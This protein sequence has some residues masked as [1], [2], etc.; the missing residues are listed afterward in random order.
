MNFGSKT[1]KIAG[2]FFN[3]EVDDDVGDQFLFATDNVIFRRVLEQRG[4]TF[5]ERLEGEAK[6]GIPEEDLAKF[7][8]TD[9][10]WL[11]GG[12]E[13][14]GILRDLIGEAIDEY[15]TQLYNAKA[16]FL[17][18][19]KVEKRIE[20]E[21]KLW[22]WAGGSRTECNNPPHVHRNSMLSGIYYIRGL[23]RGR[24]DDKDLSG[25]VVFILSAGGEEVVMGSYAAPHHLPVHPVEGTLLIFPSFLR[26]FVNRY[27]YTI[28]ERVYISFNCCVKTPNEVLVDPSRRR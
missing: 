26:H 4:D 1:K 9:G 16:D 10:N 14:R 28:F 5:H 18:R 12:G 15:L 6:K 22:G 24:Y 21:I 13:A 8:Q 3:V 7:W 2:G 23:E 17:G 11:G 19:V 20:H 25:C 27:K